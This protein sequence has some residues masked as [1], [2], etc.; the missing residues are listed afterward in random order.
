MKLS[1][2]LI[3]AFAML[4]VSA[5][6]M[7]TASFAWFSINQDV[8]VDGMAITATAD[9]AL[10]VKGSTNDDFTSHGTNNFA[11]VELNPVTSA[12]G[13]NFAKL[14]EGVRVESEVD[15]NA[16]WGE[17]DK[18]AS[19]YL[20][21]VALTNAAAGTNIYV[22]DSVYT[23]KN[24]GANASVAVSGITITPLDKDGNEYDENDEATAEA[25]KLLKSIR[26]AVVVNDKD[27][28]AITGNAV[29]I[30]NP[31]GGQYVSGEGAGLLGDDG[32]TWTLE[33]PTFSN[34]GATDPTT[35]ATLTA[36]TNYTVH[37]YIWIEGQ[38]TTCT[39]EN[40]DLSRYA[41]EVSFKGT[42]TN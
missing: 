24:I 1:R 29:H 12:D 8:V 7:S 40:V 13:V 9:S 20:E 16:T 30:Y 38:D 10:V 6:L 14:A 27:D 26:I 42:A 3:P 21:K 5:V 28:K 39:S 22:L 25:G 15:A 31:N 17:D 41:I 35:I 37:V 11:K 18:F 4:L 36:D 2:R 34:F 32:K 33:A 23:M 19:A